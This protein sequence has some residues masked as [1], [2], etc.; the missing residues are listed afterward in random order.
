LLRHM[1]G[2]A[3]AAE[4]A[5]AKPWES[6]D[7]YAVVNSIPAPIVVTSAT[8]EVEAANRA[9]VEYFGKT[10][11]ELKGWSTGDWIHPDDLPRAVAKWK[12]ALE[13]GRAYENESRHRRHDGI[14]RWVQVRVFPLRDTEGR[15]SRW[16]L[17]QT[18]VDDRKQ[19]EEALAANER[20]LNLTIN[21]IPALAWSA[22]TDGS[23]DFFNRHYLEYVGLSPEQAHGWGW[24]AAVHPDDLPGLA[25]VWRNILASGRQGEVEA[26]LRR[27]DGA[28]RW[29]LFRAAPLHDGEG[30]IVKWFGVN[31]DI[32][33]RKRAEQALAAG[34][35]ELRRAHE[36]LTNA[37]RLS[38]TGSFTASVWSDDHI[39]SEE[40]YRIV[41]W[42]PR[43][44]GS[45]QEFRRLVHPEDFPSFND[46]DLRSIAKGV[47][48]D[49][50][51]RIITPS[52]KVKHLHTVA[53]RVEDATGRPV[54]MG[55]V[56]DVTESKVAE[57]A[58]AASERN[59]SLIINTIPGLAWSTSTD[60][61]VEFVNQ[62]FLDFL[63]V[64]L[65]QVQESGWTFPFHPD[66]RPGT[67]QSIENSL[68]SGSSGEA[69]ARMR[70]F[71]GEY[72]WFLC[73]RVPLRDQSGNVVRWFGINFDID[74]RKRAEEAQAASERNLSLIINTMPGLAWS[75]RADGI[76]DFLN[77]NY[78]DYLGFRREQAKNLAWN[79]AVCPDDADALARMGRS[80]AASGAVG[81]VEA[82]LRRFDG[83]FRWFLCRAVPLRDPSGRVTRWFGINFDIEDRKRAEEELRDTQTKL[84]YM[85][86]VLTMGQLTASI[87]H[88]VNQPL[89]GIITNANTC[90]RMLA[91]NPPNVDGARE[92]ARRT[93]RDGN[94][95]SEVIKRLRALFGKRGSAVEPVDL[96]EAT[97]EVIAL[98]QSRLHSNRVIL[99]TE[100]ADDL[101]YARGDRVQLQ[102]V[103]LNLIQNASDAMSSVEDRPRQITVKTEREGAEELRLTVQDAGTGFQ[104][105]TAERL[106]D[107][108]YTTKSEGMG[109]GLSVS[110]SIIE[111]HGGRM[112]A[113]PNEG[114]GACFAFSVPLYTES[115]GVADSACILRTGATE[116]GSI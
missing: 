7:F 103:I 33:D 41:E 60:G 52:G 25:G 66:D 9:I 15:I 63:G 89:S 31:T 110:R 5:R 46:A 45:F 53:H 116:R 114:P 80:A 3:N 91:A 68:A 90:L 72:R 27:H 35:A 38:H 67:L 59:L 29:F 62:H 23:A 2:G 57:E 58:L 17:L 61:R 47:D 92:T 88:E 21:T 82:R 8:G 108:F 12:L 106:F 109:I 39:W 85:T 55:A 107:A 32:Q 69:E 65:E 16:L 24:S 115:V 81:E 64:S 30:K 44:K 19:A 112:W 104:P 4:L 1:S 54:F 40:L 94:R 97:R 99:R 28:Y 48:F 98:S 87:A 75:T 74:D 43:R 26:R 70:R 102:Q 73:R 95:A 76:I 71:D 14:F 77:Q 11:D 78:L 37:Q 34:E 42:D 84:A 20:N 105:E 83:E 111:R 22:R 36:H 100:L 79:F 13:T 101:P 51:F 6:I 49:Q 96:N 18:D 93:I 113:K 56:Q 10:L 86:R 50:A